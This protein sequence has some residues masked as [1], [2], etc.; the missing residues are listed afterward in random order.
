MMTDS[1][2]ENLRNLLHDTCE[3]VRVINDALHQPEVGEQEIAAAASACARTVVLL[4]G[5]RWALA[6]VCRKPGGDDGDTSRSV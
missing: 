5:L 3:N 2:R 1:A 6:V 4:K